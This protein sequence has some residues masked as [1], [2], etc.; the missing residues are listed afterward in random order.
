MNDLQNIIF[1]SIATD[2]NV[3]IKSLYLFLP[4]LMP[5]SETQVMFNESIMNNYTIT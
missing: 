1:T 4:I 5:N 3:T 2:I